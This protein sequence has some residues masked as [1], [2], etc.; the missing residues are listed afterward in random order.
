MAQISRNGSPVKRVTAF[1]Y[2]DVLQVWLEHPASH[3]ELAE[4]ARACGSITRRNRAARFNS[5]YRQYIALRQPRQDALEWVARRRDAYINAVEISLDVAFENWV[6]RE[7]VSEYLHRHLVRRWH[8][9]KQPI[10]FVGEVNPSR[11]DARRRARNLL[12]LYPQDDCR[13]TGEIEVP[14]LHIEWRAKGIKAVH[15]VGIT[16]GADLLTFDH[17]EFWRHRLLLVDI[18]E[19]QLGRAYR[20]ARR[21]AKDR[22]PVHDSLG[23]NLDRIAGHILVEGRARIAQK[24]IDELR[25]TLGVRRALVRIDNNP[26][27]PPP[28]LAPF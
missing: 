27:L 24:V 13:A 25:G 5:R 4:V 19:E 7:E 14:V 23:R 18:N 3:G 6:D 2:F 9:P 28:R 12:A 22:K 20:N 17:R 26:F 1:G 21:K 10:R 11:Y 16:A 15:S 8:G